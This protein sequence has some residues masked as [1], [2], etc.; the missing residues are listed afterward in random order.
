MSIIFSLLPTYLV[1]K[2]ICIQSYNLFGPI[3][4][5]NLEARMI[6]MANYFN[7]WDQAIWNQKAKTKLQESCN[8]LLFQEV[9]TESHFDFLTQN[10]SKNYNLYHFDQDFRKGSDSEAVY[11]L[12]MA[13]SK[14]SDLDSHLNSYQ[15]VG[16]EPFRQNYSGFFDAIRRWLEVGKGFAVVKMNIRGFQFFLV[17]THLHPTSEEIR[18]NQVLQLASYLDEDKFKELPV[19]LVG[20]FNSPPSSVEMKALEKVANLQ[21]LPKSSLDQEEICTYC[22]DNPYTLT[23]GKRNID[24]IFVRSGSLIGSEP[25]ETAVYPKTGRSGM[26][27]SDHYGV[28]SIISFKR[29]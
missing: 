26:F 4:G 3:Y 17:N 16:T 29:L 22:N 2:P 10:L 14:Q 28:R 6:G 7:K 12:A 5:F 23:F 27:F 19:V 11:G 1:A 24:H 13:I 21:Y 20:D 25:I 9:W 8:V 15:V 18:S